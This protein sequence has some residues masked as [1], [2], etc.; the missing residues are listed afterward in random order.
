MRK[1]VIVSSCTEDWGG[2]EEL[3]GR[4]IP[5]LQEAGYQ[6]SVVKYFINRAHPEFVK[7]AEKGVKLIEIF[8]KRSIV[9][10]VGAKISKTFSDTALALKL[11]GPK[12]EDFSNYIRIMETENPELVIISQGIN[13]DGL[14]MAYQW[15]ISSRCI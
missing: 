3:W 8:P 12:P 1:I 6:I 14:K 7:L 13:F 9:R 4:S 10:R 11:S 5:P 2:S 15:P